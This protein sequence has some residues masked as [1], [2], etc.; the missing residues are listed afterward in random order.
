MNAPQSAPYQHLVDGRSVAASTGETLPM[1]DPSTGAVFAH[2]AAG[3][4]DDIDRAVRAA[5][6]AL[7]RI[8]ARVHTGTDCT[9]ALAAGQHLLLW[10]TGAVPHAWQADAARRGSLAVDGAG[11]V[12][13]DR[14]LRSV[15]HPQVFAVGDCA[16][17][18]P[19]LSKAGVHAVRQ[20]PF[21][22]AGLRAAIGGGR[23]PPAYR[24][25]RQFLVLIGT[26]NG[27]AIASR[28][29]LWAEGRWVWRWKQH[30]DRGF[31]A[32]LAPPRGG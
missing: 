20:G 15:S 18:A 24:P 3:T 26:G 16:G 14:H 32:G 19:P 5:Q 8:G 31:I 21:L 22:D 6:A 9:P 1:I 13:V 11:F 27:R 10:A 17:H 23:P 25:Q 30:I 2:I 12:Q 28:G 4:A 29:R 7:Q